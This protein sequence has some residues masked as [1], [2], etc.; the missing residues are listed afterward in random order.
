MKQ[1]EI[2]AIATEAYLFLYPLVIM[3]ATRRQ[4]TNHGFRGQDSLG[5]MN[6]PTH[7]RSIPFPGPDFPVV[8][9]NFDVLNTSVWLDVTDEPF[10]I[11][12]PSITDRHF[13]FPLLDMWTD[14]FAVPGARTY[15]TDAFQF[16]ICTPEWRGQLPENT[17]R[18][19]SPTPTV[20]MVGRILTRGPG[21]YERIH[22]IQDAMRMSPL[23]RWPECAQP[24]F[25]FDDSVDMKTH[26]FQQVQ[27][28]TPRAFFEGAVDLALKHRPHLTDWPQVARLRRI[29]LAL[30]RPL[31][32]DSLP[33]STREALEASPRLATKRVM[34]RLSATFPSKNGWGITLD[35]GVWGNSYV[36]RA[37]VAMFG[38]AANPTEESF[39][40]RLRIDA[41][42]QALSGEHTYVLRF[43]G[44]QT[45]PAD[46]FW[47]LTPYNANNLVD[48]NELERYTLGDRS[49]LK[50]EAD[51]AIEFVL[52]H[53]RPLDESQVQNWLP[54]PKGLFTLSLRVYL[55][56][57][58]IFSKEW[59][60]PPARRVD[61]V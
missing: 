46:A 56:R 40:S 13:T 52:S 1:A 3:E 54:V 14:V 59:T 12:L 41:D 25:T 20:W 45:P 10:I 42:G 38:L 15:G 4:L 60:P 48:A 57:E 19:D 22:E 16:A 21:D 58:E 49:D 47:S 55:P 29:G 36:R 50:I 23:S 61:A 33:P 8:G 24:D 31:D 9:P 5:V 26:P 34:R 18:I 2:E 35:A 32:F 37:A 44:G 30:D 39:N 28:M 7:T 51:G 11:S 6:W 17:V 43:E 53:E 27:K